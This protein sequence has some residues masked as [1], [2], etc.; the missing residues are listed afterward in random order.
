MKWLQHHVLTNESSYE[1]LKIHSKAMF[2]AASI[3]AELP[4]MTMELA[5]LGLDEYIWNTR[6]NLMFLK[7]L[8]GIFCVIWR[9]INEDH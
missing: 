8:D 7:D 3:A 6:T 4:N 5:A 1:W 9:R 2:Q